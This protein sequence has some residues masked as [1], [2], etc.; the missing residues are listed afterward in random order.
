MEYRS[1][2]VGSLLR[3]KEVLEARAARAEGRISPEELRGIEDRAIEDALRKQ[4]EVGISVYSDGEM[5]RG[6]WLTDMAEAVEGF[7][8]GDKVML[9]WKGPGG[10]AEPTTAN[11]VGAKL[12]KARHLT[13]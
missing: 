12:R 6:S 4:R 7:V 3:P 9:E 1:D 11:A 13:G 8:A 5:R 2:H 10:G